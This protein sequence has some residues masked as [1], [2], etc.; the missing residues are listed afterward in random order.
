MQPNNEKMT[1][2]KNKLPKNERE[3]RHIYNN[4]TKNKNARYTEWVFIKTAT[5][6]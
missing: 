4:N 3:K 5:N 6:S 2:K 1:G